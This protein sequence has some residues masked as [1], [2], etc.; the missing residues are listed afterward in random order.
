MLNRRTFIWN[1]NEFCQLFKEHKTAATFSSAYQSQIES[2]GQDDTAVS[3]VEVEPPAKKPRLESTTQTSGSPDMS[4][5]LDTLDYEIEKQR[6][7]K[8]Y[9]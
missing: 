9:F 5:W 8:W 2:G 1:A 3:A 6:V 4:K 7:G